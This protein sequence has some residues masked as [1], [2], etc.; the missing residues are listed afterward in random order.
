[1]YTDIT[2]VTGLI[3]G[4]ADGVG[5]WRS[6]GVDPSIFPKCL[7]TTCERLVGEGRFEPQQPIQMLA[8]SYQEI[9]EDKIPLVGELGNSLAVFLKLDQLGIPIYSHN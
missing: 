7:M 5:G 9:L 6:Y 8:A 2:G 1:M 4:V 3:T